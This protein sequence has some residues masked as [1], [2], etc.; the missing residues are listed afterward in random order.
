MARTPRIYVLAGVNGAGKSSVAGA[1]FRA[2][3]ADYFNPDE[4]AAKLRQA[5]P[6]LSA[7]QSNSLAWESGRSLL[8]R[9]IAQRLDFAF[10]TTLGGSTLTGML[11]RAVD[12]GFEVRIW[13]VGLSS[14]EL[15]LARVKERVRRGGHDIPEDRI[16]ER[17]DASRMNLI[18]LLLS[19]AELRVYDNSAAADPAQGEEPKPVLLLHVRRGRLVKVRPLEL[20]PDWAKP[21]LAAAL[22]EQR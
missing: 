20:V 17:F 4:V 19:L 14:V 21:V 8:E 18:Q 11:L 6:G 2:A 7:A 12:L 3:G 16:R 22:R 13:Y 9:A 10:E 1:T 15:H 5:D